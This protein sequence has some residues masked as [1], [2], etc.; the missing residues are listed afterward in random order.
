[1]GIESIKAINISSKSILNK[2]D[3]GGINPQGA[4]PYREKDKGD[5][6][7][8]TPKHDDTLSSNI[9]ENNE[10]S[11]VFSLKNS[12]INISFSDK[13]GSVLPKRKVGKHSN[14]TRRY[15]TTVL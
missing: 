5:N 2:L 4:I 6:S 7:S 13:I 1:M 14:L 10:F 9:E 12:D 15:R 8:T 11:S 3:K